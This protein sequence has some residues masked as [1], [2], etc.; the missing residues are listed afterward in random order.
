MSEE[1]C[2]LKGAVLVDVSPDSSYGTF[3]VPG[4]GRRRVHQSGVH[5][6]SEVYWTGRARSGAIMGEVGPGKLVLHGWYAD[7]IGLELD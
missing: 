1:R 2:T 5:D 6:D 4:V 7:R 3:E